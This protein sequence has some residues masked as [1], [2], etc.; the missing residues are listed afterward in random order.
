MASASDPVPVATFPQEHLRRFLLAREAGDAEAMRR[1]WEMLVVDLFDRITAQVTYES[2][3][4]LDADERE[5]AVQ[6]CLQSFSDKLITSFKGTS[7]GELVNAMKTL[8]K[9]RCIDVQ[10]KETRHGGESLDAGWADDD[11]DRPGPDWERDEA[12]N[13]FDR[14]QLGRDAQGF[15]DWMLPQLKGQQREVMELTLRGDTLEEICQQLSVS[16]PNAYQLRS[17]ANKALVKLK[18][19]YDA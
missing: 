10:R 19:Q 18:E 7:V 17:R 15:L 12:W 3:G 1:W 11:P 6:L 5:D 8:V 9:Y 13:R 4:H 16:K 2:I 14:E